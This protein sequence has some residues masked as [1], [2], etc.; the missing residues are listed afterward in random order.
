MLHQSRCSDSHE[1]HHAE[2]LDPVHFISIKTS[3]SLFLSTQMRNLCI[4]V[5]N[6]L[7][8]A[9]IFDQE[10]MVEKQVFA[11]ENDLGA[12]ASTQS[13]ERVIISSVKGG[14]GTLAE[15]FRSAKQIV[16]F[17]H[18]LHLPI[19]NTYKTPNT[20]GKD[21]LAVA[22]A[23]QALHKGRNCLVMD[24]G[25][26]LTYDFVTG[27]GEYLGG[28]ISPGLH[29]RFKALHDYTAKLPLMDA[30][31]VVPLTG[32]DTTESIRSGVVNGMRFEMEKAI[33]EYA[34]KYE[35]VQ[36][37]LC[38]GDAHFFESRIKGVIFVLPDLVLFGLNHTLLYNA[39]R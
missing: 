16:A 37:I 25:T 30:N 13:F 26:C 6:T 15:H 28:A 35:D 19:I 5:G 7:M 39:P 11:S 9:A 1:K 8:K 27:K 10:E 31:G 21:R 12:W 22:V 2:R 4:D 23:T 29:M 33:E 20:L 14:E 32:T 38:G 36:V 18:T 3:R 24:A 17:H 34:N